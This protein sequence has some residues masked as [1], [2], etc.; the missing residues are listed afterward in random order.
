MYRHRRGTLVSKAD[1]RFNIARD[2]Y[3]HWMVI[4][5]GGGGGGGAPP[6]TLRQLCYLQLTYS[7]LSM[8]ESCHCFAT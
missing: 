6:T 2:G 3:I 7:L 5:V 4:S 8:L 1:Q